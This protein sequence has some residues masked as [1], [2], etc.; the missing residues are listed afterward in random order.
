[1][2]S[3][4]I[5]PCATSGRIVPGRLFKRVRCYRIRGRFEPVGEAEPR[6]ERSGQ[7]GVAAERLQQIEGVSMA[8]AY[9]RS[10]E[11]VPVLT[12]FSPP[13]GLARPG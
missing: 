6:V 13:A 8:A 7:G 11:P 3:R 4:L 5:R 10:Q 9:P 12:G 2:E 1:M